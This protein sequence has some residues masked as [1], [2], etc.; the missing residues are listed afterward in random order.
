MDVMERFASGLASKIKQSYNKFAVDSQIFLR[1]SL[2]L[3]LQ[4]ICESAA[5]YK[6]KPTSILKQKRF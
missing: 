2:V 4:K 5:K 6:V 3:I 1:I